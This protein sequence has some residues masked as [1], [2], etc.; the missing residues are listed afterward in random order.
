M[1][2]TPYWRCI[3]AR[4]LQDLE[5]TAGLGRIFDERRAE[6]PRRREFLDAARARARLRPAI[7]S[8]TSAPGR[9]EQLVHD[10]QVHVRV[11]AQ[12]HGREVKAKD[13]DR[14]SQPAQATA[15]EQGRVVGRERAMDDVELGRELTGIGIGRGFADRR[16]ASARAGPSARAVAA[17]PRIQAGDRAT[18]RFVAAMRA[19]VRRAIGQRAELFRDVGDQR[20]QRQF[21]RRANAVAPG[22]ISNARDD[23][24][25]A[26]VRGCP[27]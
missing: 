4:R 15:G 25:A 3:C 22:K 17:T 7:H 27:P 2:S 6:Q 16:A 26:C 14:T 20:R 5:F 23:A 10:A 24:C 11:L 19:L 8:R 9:A 12:V 13:A 18:I 1:H 21:A